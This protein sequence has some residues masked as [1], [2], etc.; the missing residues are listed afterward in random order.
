MKRI[1][2]FLA[3][4]SMAALPALADT[5]LWLRYPALSPDGQTI[6]FS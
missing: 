6:A 3:A 2:S 5:P 4:L 1:S